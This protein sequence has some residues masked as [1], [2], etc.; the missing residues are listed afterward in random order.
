LTA[1]DAL[2]RHLDKLSRNEAIERLHNLYTVVD[3]KSSRIKILELLNELRDSS[4]FEEI[5]N[6]FISDTDSDVRIEAAKLLAFNY[7]EQRGKAI[8]PL[9]WVLENEVKPEIK[10]TALRL[11]VPLANRSEYRKLVIHSLKNA[12][13]SKYD[14]MKMEAAESLGFLKERGA[15]DDLIE[16]LKD[17]NIQVRIS[18]IQALNNL[19]EIPQKAIPLLLSNLGL[20]SYDLWEFAYKSLKKNL[21]KKKLT[22]VLLKILKATKL[23]KRDINTAY[24]RRGIVKA[25]GKLGDERLI[26]PLI[27]VLKD[28]HYFVVEE[29]IRSLDNIDAN[30][31]ENYRSLLKRKKINIKI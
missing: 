11:L 16:L 13:K 15:T 1:L 8:Q 27:D 20:E 14:K 18:A 4:H 17:S 9:I 26:N 25:L 6:Y 30:W 7:L 2:I 23:D 21:G 5:E 10:Y 28:W 22:D 3:D 24:L 12:L 31:R 29:T 19:D